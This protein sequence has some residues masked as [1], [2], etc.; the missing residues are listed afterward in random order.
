MVSVVPK[1]FTSVELQ[2]TRWTGN[3]ISCPYIDKKTLAFLFPVLF[4]TFLNRP[5]VRVRTAGSYF[6]SLC[7][8]I[9]LEKEN[10]NMVPNQSGVKRSFLLIFKRAEGTTSP[11]KIF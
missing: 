7:S 1:C 4:F 2:T 6:N 8:R 3:Y 10:K 5:T 9:T 11:S